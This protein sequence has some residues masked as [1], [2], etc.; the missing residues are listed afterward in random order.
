MRI[1][2]HAAMPEDAALAIGSFD[3]VHLGHQAMLAKVVAGARECALTPA[4]LTFEPLPREFFTPNLAPA[5]LSSLQE[6]LGLI[7]RTGIEAAIVERFDRDFA[8]ITAARF[9]ERIARHYSARWVMVGQDFRYGAKRQG[10][11]A[12]L[13]AARRRPAF[14]AEV[15]PP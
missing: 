8:A 10:E 1:V 3:G 13:Q 2:H 4:A 5:R 6:R 7:A 11:V 14:E 12:S 9:E 15:L